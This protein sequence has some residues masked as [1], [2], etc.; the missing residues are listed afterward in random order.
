MT[1]D[2]DDPRL[3]CRALA[4]HIVTLRVRVELDIRSADELGKPVP[5]V[6]RQTPANLSA[7]AKMVSLP[8]SR[9]ET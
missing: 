3:R 7:W 1:I 4:A 8:Q 2:P 6:I 5:P 9:H